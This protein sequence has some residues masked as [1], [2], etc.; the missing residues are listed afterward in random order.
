MSSA[1]AS[2]YLRGIAAAPGLARGPLFRLDEVRLDEVRL[3]EV[4]REA[5]LPPGARL[6]PAGASDRERLELAID[7]ACAELTALMQR[8]GD[9]NAKALLAFQVA[10]LRDPVLTGPAFAAIADGVALEC[11]W[12]QALALQI[13]DYDSADDAYFR[14]RAAD[15]RDM[16]DRVL[17]ASSGTALLPIPPGSIVTGTDLPPSRFLEMTWD[18]GGIALTEGSTSSHVAMLA[19]AWGVP[20]LVGLDQAILQ[21]H[22]EALLDADNGLLITEPDARTA[23]EFT[24]RQRRTR[25]AGSAAANELAPPFTTADGERVQVLINV[26]DQ[27]ELEHLDPACCDGIGLVRTEL[28]LRGRQDLLDEAKQNDAY[29][30]ILRWAAGRSVTV[31]LLDAGGDKPI[32]GYTVDAEANP[33]LGLR[34][35][36]LSLVHREVLAT[37]LRALARAAAVQPLQIMVPMV[38]LPEEMQQVRQMLDAAIH[39]LHKDG[40]ECVRPPLGMMVEVPAAALTCDLF[41]ADFFSIGSNDLI[42][43]LTACSRDSRP[44]GSLRDPLQPAVLRVIRG[45]V[46]SARARAIPVSLCGDMAGDPHCISALLAAGLRSLSVTPAALPAVKA[47]IARYRH[48]AGDAGRPP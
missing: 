39:S 24:L 47:A 12:L 25:K 34:G 21:G 44:L 36:R 4:R 20:M 6:P 2:L 42:Q 48:A 43:Y 32:G 9:A 27:T 17:R 13:R 11:A 41:E 5:A 16:R 38:T 26:A 14:A 10:M 15:L 46:D 45:I 19:R 33:F 31:R 22:G 30:R 40:L 7:A 18:G 8:P 3:D 35:V 1:T 29:C 23:A 37:Q 28:L